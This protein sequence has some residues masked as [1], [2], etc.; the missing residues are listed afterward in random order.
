M[1]RS[2]IQ[3]LV[4]CGCGIALGLSL[5]FA[6]AKK[7]S[8][9][10]KKLPNMPGFSAYTEVFVTRW[11]NKLEAVT[12]RKSDGSQT[13]KE[14]RPTFTTVAGKHSLKIESGKGGQYFDP[15][16]VLLAAAASSISS[17]FLQRLRENSHV[18]DLQCQTRAKDPNGEI[19]FHFVITSPDAVEQEVQSMCT[20]LHTCA[21]LEQIKSVY[22]I[23]VKVKRFLEI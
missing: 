14:H 17:T 16:Q 12:P 2:V 7:K 23:T 20:E 8:K 6:A 11:S 22:F 9:Q 3:L 4:A 13:F 15:M 21:V 10:T 1:E 5:G 18:L 19:S